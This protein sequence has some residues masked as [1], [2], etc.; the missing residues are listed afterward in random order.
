MRLSWSLAQDVKYKAI[1]NNFY[2]LK[3]FLF[4]R[5]GESNEGRTMEFQ[6]LSSLYRVIC[7]FYK[8][9]SLVKLNTIMVR[10]QIH[11]DLPE[12]YKPLACY[13]ARMRDEFNFYGNFC[14][15]WVN[16]DFN[17]PHRS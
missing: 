1:E 14:R 8:T 12:S 15:V 9:Y 7:W 17:K 11:D 4:R 6:E 2:V 5:L 10:V 16:I 3:F 13:L